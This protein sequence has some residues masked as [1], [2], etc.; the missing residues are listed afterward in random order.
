MTMAQI[1]GC[2]TAIVAV[3]VQNVL[4]EDPALLLANGGSLEARSCHEVGPSIS[5]LVGVYC[6]CAWLQRYRSSQT[7]L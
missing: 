5:A 1:M 2:T 3:L 6:L 4:Q 7:L